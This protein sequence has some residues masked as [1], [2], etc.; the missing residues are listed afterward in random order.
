M[1]LFRKFICLCTVVNM[2]SDQIKLSVDIWSGFLLD[3]FIMLETLLW[4]N[5][6]E[7]KRVW[8]PRRKDC[9]LW[10]CY[11]CCIDFCVDDSHTHQKKHIATWRKIWYAS[12]FQNTSTKSKVSVFL[13]KLKTVN[14]YCNTTFLKIYIYKMQYTGWIYCFSNILPNCLK[15]VVLPWKYGTFGCYIL[16]NKFYPAIQGQI[17]GHSCLKSCWEYF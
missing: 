3:W 13:F 1:I 15:H 6:L 17:F 12:T 14:I 2:I 5:T 16:L 10:I 11:G 8:E 7:A 9:I 4:I